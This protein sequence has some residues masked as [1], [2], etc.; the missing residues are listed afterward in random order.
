MAEVTGFAL[1]AN[2]DG[3]LELAATTDPAEGAPYGRVWYARQTAPNGDWTGWQPLDAPPVHLAITAPAA[4]HDGRR[5]LDVVVASKDGTVWLRGQTDPDGRQWSDWQPLG[6]PGGEPPPLEGLGPPVLA[7]NQDGRLEI[8]VVRLDRPDVPTPHGPESIWHAWQEPDGDWSGWHPLGRPGSGL[9]EVIAVAPNFARRLELFAT[10]G[11]GRA[12]WHRWQQPGT[13]DGWAPW[14]SL[15]APPGDTQ[16]TTPVLG[17][18]SDRHVLLFTVTTARRV[19]LRRKPPTADSG[20]APW[21]PVLGRDWFEQVGVGMHRG[22]EA[23]GR[24]LVVATSQE[25]RL[26]HT[27]QLS[28]RSTIFGDWR[29][30][31]S[32]TYER[33]GALRRPTLAANADGRLE[34]FVHGGGDLYQY[35][36]TG[37]SEHEPGVPVWSEGRVWPP[38]GETTPAAPAQQAPT[39]TGR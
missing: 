28:S 14:A 27:Q 5:R 33:P 13:P 25:H 7:T 18:S 29:S 21:E 20:W 30:F 22:V 16:P 11:N 1:A 24:L 15:G 26:W 19:W 10:E 23:A 32:S 12:I 2:Q 38:P 37:I 35:T 3:R 31:G 4:A 36:Q 34:L 6:R 39:V 17:R 8:F 9:K